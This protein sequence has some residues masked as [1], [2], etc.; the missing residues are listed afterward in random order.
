M[1]YELIIST[2]YENDLKAFNQHHLLYF[3]KLEKQD[4]CHNLHYPHQYRI[5]TMR[6]DCCSCSVRIFGDDMAGSFEYQFVPFQDWCETLDESFDN[7]VYLFDVISNLVNQG[8]DVD[9]F[10]AWNGNENN[11]PIKIM[12]INTNDIIKEHFAFFENVYFYYE[13]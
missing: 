13:K 9:S 10:V 7:V 1:C 5:A 8:H 11:K 4:Y 6:P 3:E 2:N 12:N